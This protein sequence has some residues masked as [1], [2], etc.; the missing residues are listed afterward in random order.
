YLYMEEK[1]IFSHIYF[2]EE[3]K[4]N[5]IPWG[6]GN[7]WVLFALSEL[8]LLMPEK[9]PDYADMLNRF[10]TLTKGFLRYQGKNGMWHQ[11][12][13]DETTYEECSGTCMYIIGMARGVKNGWL[14]RNIV[15]NIKRAWERMASTCLSEAGDLLGVCVG[16]GCS[17]ER[18]YYR[19][20]GTCVNDDHGTG[21]F[22]L[23]AVEVIDL[24]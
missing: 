22:L 11:I 7:G 10:Q 17:M 1:K 15:P 19:K 9:H 5:K 14:S 6:R 24:L 20:L 8:L 16:S 2:V 12:I 18:E 13:D 4:Q 21:V 3:K 23:A